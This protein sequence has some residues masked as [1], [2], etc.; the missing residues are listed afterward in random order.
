MEASEIG[1]FAARYHVQRN[2]LHHRRD[3]LPRLRLL[4]EALGKGYSA[5]VVARSQSKVEVVK[6]LVANHGFSNEAV[7]GKP[8]CKYF[9]V[10]DLTLPG[11]LDDAVRGANYVVHCASPLPFAEIPAERQQAEMIDPAVACTLN[12]LESVRGVGGPTVRRVVVLTSLIAFASAEAGREVVLNEGTLNDYITPPFPNLLVA[13][14]AAKTAALRSSM[15]W[16]SSKAAAGAEPLGFDLVN[17]GPAYVVGRHPLA[18]TPA[19]LMGTSNSM[20]LTV[21]AGRAADPQL[22]LSVGGAVHMDDLTTIFL[23]SL[24]PA[25]KVRTPTSGPSRGVTNF[26]ISVN[27]EWNDARRL[28]AAK[29]P[30]HAESG[31]LPN[32]G[33]RPTKP[34]I[35]ID[36]RKTEETFGIKL[37]GLEEMVEAIVPQYVELLQKEKDESH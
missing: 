23:E 15:D 8:Y 35:V 6:E 5:H 11:A 21:V 30:A 33:D 18:R 29:W 26:A 1:P 9:I 2:S 32:Q 4:L 36:S 31:L 22:P 25:G 27:V 37:R 24:D 34:R 17:L 12:M 16:M 3:G 19:D 14:C 7:E 13:Y 28:V 10:P 20:P